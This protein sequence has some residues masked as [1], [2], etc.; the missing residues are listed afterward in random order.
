MPYKILPHTADTRVQV[1]SRTKEELF[2]EAAYALLKTMQPEVEDH[3]IVPVKRLLPTK[4]WMKWW[5]LSTARVSRRKSRAYAPSP[6]LKVRYT[7]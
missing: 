6:L 3:H 1:W 7:I 4:T 5:A 2:E